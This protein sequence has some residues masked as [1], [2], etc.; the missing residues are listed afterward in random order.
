MIVMSHDTD[1]YR[2]TKHGRNVRLSLIIGLST[3]ASTDLTIPSLSQQIMSP[4][5]PVKKPSIIKQ[6]KPSPTSPS[7]V[8]KW[9]AS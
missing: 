2:T 4:D 6:I 5:Q 8:Q 1:S 9:A 7:C 3:V